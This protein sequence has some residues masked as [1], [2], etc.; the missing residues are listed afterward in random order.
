M[1]R[2]PEIIIEQVLERA[3]IVDVIRE[4]VTLKKAG[5]NYKGRC[6]FH[7]DKTPS[8]VVSPLKGICKCFACGKG[9]NV[10]WFLQEHEG[11]NYI[12]AVR[13]LGEKFGVAVPTEDLTPEEVAQQRECE[14]L[15]AAM[16]GAQE[17]FTKN[18]AES[19]VAL[20]YLKER[21]ITPETMKTFGIGYSGTAYISSLSNKGYDKAVLNKADLCRK[22][23]DGTGMYETFRNRIL[24]PFFNRRGEVI[25]YT[26]RDIKG[27]SPAKYLNSNDTPLFNKGSNIYG[28]RQAQSEVRRLDRV[29]I[30]EGQFDVLSLHQ[31]GV[32]NVVAGSGT[33]FTDQ[34]IKLLRGLTNE[35]TFIYDGDAAG[36]HLSLI[37]I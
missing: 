6:P 36:L 26:G 25:G 16:S 22:K 24:L 19:K 37:H 35:V 4:Y 28:M 2:I 1:A 23:E 15:K 32:K 29:Y 12:E 3:D 27:T 20:D 7:N 31:N 11:M 10:I 18:L 30:V 8:F 14:S 34:Q 33:A 9:G 13:Y 5:V 17:L 21:K